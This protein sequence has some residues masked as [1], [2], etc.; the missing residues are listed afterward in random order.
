MHGA[1][2][3]PLFVGEGGGGGVRLKLDVQDRGRWEI[4]DVDGQGSGGVLKIRQFSWTSCVYRP[5]L[6]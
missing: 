6:K 3:V 1:V 5:Y 4:F 2:V